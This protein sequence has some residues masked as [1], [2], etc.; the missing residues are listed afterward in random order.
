M[1]T[2]MACLRRDQREHWKCQRD[3]PSRSV[4]AFRCQLPCDNPFY[5]SKPPKKDS[6][7]DPLMAGAWAV[8]LLVEMKVVLC[9]LLPPFFP[10]IG[11]K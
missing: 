6:T 2:S 11:E 1:C 9:T 7:D 8:F 5:S 10:M 3:K 4:K